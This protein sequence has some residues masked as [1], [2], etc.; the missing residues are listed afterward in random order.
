MVVPKIYTN[1]LN[2]VT[3]ETRHPQRVNTFSKGKANLGMTLGNAKIGKDTIII[4]LSSATLC[5]SARLGLCP[6]GPKQF[7]GNGSCY[8]L[9]A[10]RMY[11]QS[12]AFRS[13][14]RIQW[15]LLEPE[16]IA[17]EIFKKILLCSRLKNKA[18][19]IKYIRLNESGDFN[20]SNQVLKVDN[21]LRFLNEFCD[22]YNLPFIKLYTYTH[23]KDIFG[24]DM[25]KVLL[26]KLA[27]NFVI[28]GSNF[29][30]HNEFKVLPINRKERDLRVNGKKVNKYTCLDDCSKCSLCKADTGITIIQ[31][32]H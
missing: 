26:G 19:H 21:V 30:A 8:A 15:E 27:P 22:L 11:P 6:L 12:I 23:R 13:L 7:N 2:Q 5:L 20:S 1:V 16:I 32:K 31:A 18:R 28:N 24:D 9:K 14:Q 3:K 25:G 10:E 17:D 4:N 29:M